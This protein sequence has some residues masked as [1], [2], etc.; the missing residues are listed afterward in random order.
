[1]VCHEPRA[2]ARVCVC[3]RARACVFGE[4]GS[5]RAAQR[6]NL[7]YCQCGRVECKTA[8]HSFVDVAQNCGP[9]ASPRVNV[10][11]ANSEVGTLA[12]CGA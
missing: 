3:V 8:D 4:V 9:N 6:C 11:G 7:R 10:I 1:M 5:H 12:L 2:R